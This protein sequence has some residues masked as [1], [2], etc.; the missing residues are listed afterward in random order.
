MIYDNISKIGYEIDDEQYVRSK[1]HEYYLNNYEDFL[2]K[3]NLWLEQGDAVGKARKKIDRIHRKQARE[4]MKN[5]PKIEFGS[6]SE[7]E[8]KAIKD[9]LSKD[10]TYQSLLKF[11]RDINVLFDEQ[12]HT[13]VGN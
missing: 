4:R 10:K 3:F 1:I 12:G 9:R 5:E 13:S 7:E 11:G 6:I 2:K 8:E